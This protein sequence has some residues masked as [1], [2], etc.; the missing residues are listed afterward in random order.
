MTRF[1]ILGGLWMVTFVAAPLALTANDHG[2]RRYDLDDHDY[3]YWNDGED[4]QYRGRWLR[5][6]ARCLPRIPSL[7]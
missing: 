4:R 1:L 6:L 5:Q 2:E 7:A 3:H